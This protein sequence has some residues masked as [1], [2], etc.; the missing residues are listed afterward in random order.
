MLLWSSSRGGGASMT[1]HTHT[2]P[3]FD[4]AW[5][6]VCVGNAPWVFHVGPNTNLNGLCL[7]QGARQNQ[8]VMY[9][10]YTVFFFFFFF[11]WFAPIW[12]DQEYLDKDASTLPPCV[13]SHSK[14]MDSLA[15]ESMGCVLYT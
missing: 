6:Y 14:G 9:F 15:R 13:C 12:I 3:C 1:Q 8:Y 11:M 5:L 7:L 10:E 2:R 4:R